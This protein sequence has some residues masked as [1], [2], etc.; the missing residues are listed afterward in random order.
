MSRFSSF[1]G[2]EIAYRTW[3]PEDDDLPVVL[4]HGFVVDSEINWV[5]PGVVEA[6]V[7]SGRRVV[8]IDARGHG[9][10]AKPHEERFY[11]EDRMAKDLIALLDLLEVKQFDLVGYSMGA[12]VSLIVASGEPRVRRLVVGGIGASAVELGGVDTRIRPAGT[13]IAAFRAEDPSE[14]EDPLVASFRIL[15]DA[16]GADRIAMAAQAARP[17]TTPIPIARIDVP[18]LV[19]GG[20]DDLL[21]PRPEVLAEAL[22]DARLQIVPGDHLGAVTAPAFAPAIV[23][24]L[25]SPP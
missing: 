20:E 18:T 9:A 7:D 13:V 19:I 11:G 17:H 14:I 1:D 15:A 5:S 22:S 12:V 6:L 16:I 24:F 2:T 21:A 8:A 23:E 25:G 3:G 4:Q 10:S